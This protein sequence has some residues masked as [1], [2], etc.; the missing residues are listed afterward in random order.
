M[1][2]WNKQQLLGQNI[3]PEL[4]RAAS[5]NRPQFHRECTDSQPTVPD[6]AEGREVT[7]EG[8]AQ[9]LRDP[10]PSVQS[11][12]KVVSMPKRL[13]VASSFLMVVVLLLVY[14]GCA[15]APTRPTAAPY[16][17]VFDFQPPGR[18]TQPVDTTVG[19][20]NTHYSAEIASQPWAQGGLFSQFSSSL[21]RDFEELLNAKGISIRGPFRSYD[22]MTFPDKKGSALLLM[23]SITMEVIPRDITGDMS[24]G[25]SLLQRSGTSV[26]R[27][28]GSLALSGRI[29][30]TLA[31]SLS[32]EKMW[33]KSVQ[34][35][36]VTVPWTT[37]ER[38]ALPNSI[39]QAQ[40]LATLPWNDRGIRAPLA[41]AMEN[42]YQTVMESAWRYL[43]PEELQRVDIQAE[44]LRQKKV[45]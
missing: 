28:K 27:L 18:S 38:Y 30:L 20:V 9:S 36:P 1:A 23:P 17:P 5:S 15:S 3:E 21:S 45:Y 26:Y 44:E 33:T 22:D 42:Y 35:P 31:E 13:H 12:R 10:I 29:D 7:V 39:S 16:E 34:L 6:I 41:K 4:P 11:E 19:L 24:F 40:I 43:D 2:R 14:S 37:E 8:P 25:L 32:R